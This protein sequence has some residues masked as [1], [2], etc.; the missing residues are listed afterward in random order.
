[1][2]ASATITTGIFTI[3]F[4][5]AASVGSDVIELTAKDTGGRG[6][7]SKGRATPEMKQKM[8]AK[9]T[10][11]AKAAE[12]HMEGPAL[13]ESNE[14]NAEARTKHEDFAPADGGQT[15]VSKGKTSKSLIASVM[16][17][18]KMAETQA[19]KEVNARVRPTAASILERAAESASEKQIKGRQANQARLSTGQS[20]ADMMKAAGARAGKNFLNLDGSAGKLANVMRQFSDGTNMDS[21]KSTVSKQ[22]PRSLW[23]DI[24]KFAKLNGAVS[25]QNQESPWGDGMS[26]AALK[27]SVS[28][29][30]L[31]KLT[32]DTKMATAKNEDQQMKLKMQAFAKEA[33]EHNVKTEAQMK[34]SKQNPGQIVADMNKRVAD[35]YKKAMAH[36]KNLGGKTGGQEYN[37]VKQMKALQAHQQ[38]QKKEQWTTA[39]PTM[40]PTSP[41]SPMVW[42]GQHKHSAAERTV[43]FDAHAKEAAQARV[44]ESSNKKREELSNK[45]H[46][47]LM[48]GMIH[49]A[50]QP[51]KTKIDHLQIFMDDAK[52]KIA[53]GKAKMKADYGRFQK[54]GNE[55]RK[56]EAHYTQK[57]MD[58]SNEVADSETWKKINSKD[59]VHVPSVDDTA[60]TLEKAAADAPISTEMMR[61]MA[62][63]LAKAFAPIGAKVAR[64]TKEVQYAKAT[65][66]TNRMR[67]NPSFIS[68]VEKKVELS[69]PADSEK[70]IKLAEQVKVDRKNA[71]S[72]MEKARQ[73][74]LV[75][76][77]AQAAQEERHIQSESGGYGAGD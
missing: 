10:A 31:E 26:L 27:G 17:E 21:L 55:M 76:E 65:V 60:G 53:K 16:K 30:K 33:Q 44:K 28:K 12:S 69:R 2:R 54:R 59:A 3:F 75:L 62:Q 52:V 4:L 43:M 8:V 29:A 18:A 66:D 5:A 67:A 25:K 41:P 56:D 15:A 64:L 50:F 61:G 38:A 1:M 22:N 51:M 77:K 20:Q 40:A 19:A 32:A 70:N 37:M 46:M 74:Q 68:K 7:I 42:G 9:V 6:I 48:Q 71:E 23:G 58:V 13:M 14:D 73:A 34:G 72:A 39:T 47:A 45:K 35:Q 11:L 49:K 36:I 63:V 24:P 57:I